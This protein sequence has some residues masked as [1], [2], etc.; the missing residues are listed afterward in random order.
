LR[1]NILWYRN[2]SV[3]ASAGITL[4]RENIGEVVNQGFEFMVGL[5]DKAG[6]FSYQ[7]SVNGGIA[8]NK[9]KFWDETPGI[10]EYQKSTGNPM[11]A[12]LYYQ[13][14][15][16]FEDQAAVDA[17]PHWSGAR[18]GDIIFEDVNKDGEINGLDRVRSKKTSIPTFTGGFN[19]NLGYKNFYASILVQG[20]AGAERSYRTFSGEAGNFLYNDVKDRW[21]E[22]NPNSTYPRTWN[23]SKEYWMTDGQPN[24]TYW[25]RSSNYMRLK[26]VQIG[27]NLPSSIIK[28]IGLK[29]LNI[30]FSGLNLLTLTGMKDFDPESPDYAAGSIWVNSEV[31]PLNKTLNIGLSL[32][33]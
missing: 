7:L 8:H 11:Y 12:R 6:D 28:H 4:P 18:S 9:I 25:V 26:T 1:T 15:G 23:R 33:F 14:I 31:Y 13:A 10:P 3:P 22:D 21:T 19:I 20:A 32:T 24:N 17:Y 5:N 16:V 30:Y 29:G 2:A 27:Y